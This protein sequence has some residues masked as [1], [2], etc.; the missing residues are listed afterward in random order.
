MGL[1]TS[2]FITTF[3]E[4]EAGDLYVAGSSAVYKLV[5]T[6]PTG[7]KGTGQR[8]AVD[9]WMFASGENPAIIETEKWYIEEKD[10]HKVALR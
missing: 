5:E 3:G 6:A 8:W 10:S 2:I 7:P 9:G 1:D 4:D